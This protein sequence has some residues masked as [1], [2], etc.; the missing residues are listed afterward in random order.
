MCEDFN[1]HTLTTVPERNQ[2]L[3]NIST[4]L[5]FQP[6]LNASPIP[7]VSWTFE[8]VL[9]CNPGSINKLRLFLLYGP[10]LQAFDRAFKGSYLKSMLT[11]KIKIKHLYPSRLCPIL[12][13]WEHSNAARMQMWHSG[14][15][16]AACIAFGA[17]RKNSGWGMEQNNKETCSRWP[18]TSR[19]KDEERKIQQLVVEAVL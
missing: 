9:L 5:A 12:G 13:L 3:F 19:R 4:Q 2:V 11:Q 18:S 15:R 16:V 7:Q 6:S 10:I 1:S 8:P 17:W 14:S